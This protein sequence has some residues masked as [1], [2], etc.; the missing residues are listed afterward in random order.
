MASQSARDS[1]LE[2]QILAHLERFQDRGKPEDVE[3]TRPRK[4]QRVST[5]DDQASRSGTQ[6]RHRV[7]E[8]MFDVACAFLRARGDVAQFRALVAIRLAASGNAP[9]EHVDIVEDELEQRGVSSADS[10]VAPQ[11]LTPSLMDRLVRESLLDREEPPNAPPYSPDDELVTTVDALREGPDTQQQPID[12]PTRGPT[13][14]GP[15]TEGP[16]TVDA[17][18][19]SPETQPPDSQVIG[20][21]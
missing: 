15:T 14:R 20:D 18:Q 7:K 13:T 11:S 19:E 8:A 5:E 4:R 6:D 3:E 2:H 21:L 10:S 1:G 9:E 17:L 12:A 16:T